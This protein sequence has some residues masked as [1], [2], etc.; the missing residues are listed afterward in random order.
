LQVEAADLN[1]NVKSSKERRKT[2][3]GLFVRPTSS[4]SVNIRWL[5]QHALRLQN[6]LF[7]EKIPVDLE[8]VVWK[9]N[10]GFS[11]IVKTQPVSEA[12]PAPDFGGAMPLPHETKPQNLTD[13][14]HRMTIVLGDAPS[15]EKFSRLGQVLQDLKAKKLVADQIDLA[16]SDKAIIRMA[17][18]ISENRRGAAQ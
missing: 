12:L 16:F 14:K 17:E 13:S 6:L 4:A 8:K 10:T 1:L 7:T 9:T 2:N 15:S 3:T 5:S 11:A 18:Q